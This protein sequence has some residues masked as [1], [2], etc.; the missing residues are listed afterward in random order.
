MIQSVI[1]WLGIWIVAPFAASFYH[2]PM[3]AILLPVVGLGSVIGG[4][5]ST[6][7][8]LVNRS[9]MLKKLVMIEVGSYACGLL[10][11]VLWA[12]INHSIWSL[13]GGGIV[14]AFIKTTASHLLLEGENNKFAWDRD[15]VKELFGFG[16]WVLVSSMLTFLA[17]EGN[18][19]LIAAF[20]G[21][22]LLAFFTLA[23]AMNLMFWMIAQQVSNRVL[24][25]A[26]AE[27]IRERPES[28]RAV[29]AK[30]R[31]YLIIP[32]WLIALF[33]VLWGD[34]FMWIIYDPRYAESGYML[35]MLAMGT[36]VGVI[37]ASYNGLLW[38]K[39]M[40]RVSTV[41]L[42]FQIVIQV[43]GMI[44][45]HYFLGERGVVLSIAV[46]GWL[47]YP[48]G[49]YVHARIGLWEPKIDLP[50]IALSILVV[51]VNFT[52]IFSHV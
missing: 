28:L 40:V 26:Y 5:E 35:R 16:Q 33:F 10:V 44:I 36:L 51:A 30:S 17:G 13:V 4:L 49:A 31:L 19:L 25:P 37:G 48:V 29:A 6:K 8:A 38:A 46:S 18:K 39:G 42:T 9:L 47:L 27:V 2:Q 24:F 3:L 11:M 23:S 15:S 14:R 43:L 21:V 20:I 22:K 50:F 52:E 12:W 34:H 45:G 1:I 41:L 32:G 7:L